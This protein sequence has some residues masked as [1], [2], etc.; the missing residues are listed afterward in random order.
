MDGKDIKL[1]GNQ[2][3]FIREALGESQL[4]FSKRFAISQ[5]VITR[6]ENKGGGTEDMTGP[7]IILI[8]Q[9]AREKGL[10]LPS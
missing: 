7:E 6:L 5:P 8:H 10:S 1:N 4:A 9:L 3:K 2:I